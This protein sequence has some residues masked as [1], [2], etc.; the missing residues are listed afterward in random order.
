MVRS[1]G[2]K[3]HIGRVT[4]QSNY[5]NMVLWNASLHQLPKTTE[6]ATGWESSIAVLRKIT[7]QPIFWPKNLNFGFEIYKF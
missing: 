1:K 5:Y 2:Y 3:T 4:H 7:G 6:I